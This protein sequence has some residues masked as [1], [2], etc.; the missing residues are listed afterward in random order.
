MQRNTSIDISN[1]HS[2]KCVDAEYISIFEFVTDHLNAERSTISAQE[3]APNVSFY[4]AAIFMWKLL[5][6][7]AG[8]KALQD[9]DSSFDRG[10]RYLLEAILQYKT[11]TQTSGWKNGML[12]THFKNEDYSLWRCKRQMDRFSDEWW[13]ILFEHG[14]NIR[15]KAAEQGT[16]IPALL[17]F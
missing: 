16:Y 13:D 6:G 12:E 10:L 14:H 9:K 11:W 4:L 5:Y 7:W 15:L 2:L 8:Q 3:D 17:F 1:Q